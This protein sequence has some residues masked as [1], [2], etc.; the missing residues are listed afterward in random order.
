MRTLIFIIAISLALG[1]G[2]GTARADVRHHRINKN[3]SLVFVENDSWEPEGF[4]KA[5]ILR[6]MPANDAPTIDGSAGDPAWG[7]AKS[8]TVPLT[9]GSIKKATLKAVYTDKELFLLVS[10]PDPTKNDQHHPWLWSKALGRY[11]EGPQ[12]EDSLLVSFEGGC[13]WS[14]SLLAGYIYDF[15]AWRWLA[16]RSDPV[17]QAVDADG[18]VQNRMVPGLGFVKYR[19]RATKP[20]WNVKFTDFRKGILTKPWQELKRQYKWAPIAKEVFVRYQADGSP[21]PAFARRLEPP[22]VAPE[23]KAA[24]SDRGIRFVRGS[25]PAPQSAPQYRPVKLSGDAGEVAAKGRW[26]KGRWTVEFRRALVTPSRTASDSVFERVT[27]FS[28]HVFDR[29]ER[30]DKAS[31]SGRLF[32]QFEPGPR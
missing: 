12:V 13:D 22:A 21:S 5:A 6:A 25:L 27:Q 15:D 18:S 14:P 29:T 9:Y 4:G 8:L 10:W 11:L 32:L 24:L 19:S 20:V 7:R 23:K 1:T 30:V 3:N 17:G 26:H 2:V 31:E 28:I 16:A